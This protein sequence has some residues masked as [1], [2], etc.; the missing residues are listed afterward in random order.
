MGT[1]LA[2]DV[3]RTRAQIPSHWQLM[4]RRE[5]GAWLLLSGAHHGVCDLS[6]CA[7]L[8]YEARPHSAQIQK[9]GRAIALGA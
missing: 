6:V 4:Q 1:L 8:D 7:A 9:H 2:T 5:Q 3:A